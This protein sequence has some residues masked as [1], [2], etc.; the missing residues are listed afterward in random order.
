MLQHG[1]EK[2]PISF[3]STEFAA[4]GFD[5]K[6]EFVAP[7]SQTKYSRATPEKYTPDIVETRAKV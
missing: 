5:F 6:E 3:I 7:I 2:I 1:A 4:R